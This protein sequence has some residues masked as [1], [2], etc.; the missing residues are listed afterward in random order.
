MV[1]SGLSCDETDEVIFSVEEVQHGQRA[2]GNFCVTLNDQVSRTLPFGSSGEEMVSVL[3]RRRI[4]RDFAEW[5][6]Q[7][8]E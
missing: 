6:C 1:G 7:R 8:W 2:D 5:L 4:C 3:K